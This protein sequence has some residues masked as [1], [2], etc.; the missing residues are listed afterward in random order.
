MSE[1]HANFLINTGNA[2]GSDIEE[3]GEI[4]REKVYANSG[5]QLEWEIKQVGRP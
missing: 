3:L 5:V 4:V 2:T 1:K